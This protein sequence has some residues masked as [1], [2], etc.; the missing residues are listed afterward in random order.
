MTDDV[1]AVTGADGGFTLPDVPPGTYQ[2]RV[3]HEVLK[4]A[5][6]PDRDGDRR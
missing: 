6:R 3:W 1:A 4:A 2:L 5:E